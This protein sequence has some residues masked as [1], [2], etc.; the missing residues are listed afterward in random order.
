M[1]KQKQTP[2]TERPIS[3][4]E[5]FEVE[6]WMLGVR[7]FLYLIPNRIQF[8]KIDITKP[9]TSRLQLVLQSVESCDKFV[10][11]GLQRAF[12]VEFA[13]TRQVYDRKKQIADLVFDRLP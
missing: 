5:R 2:N 1:R 3:K 8:G 6:R 11:S 13:F 9:L 10:R 7:R 4:S 12:C